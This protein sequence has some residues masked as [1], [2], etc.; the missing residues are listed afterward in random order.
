MCPFSNRHPTM[1][2][3]C[4]VMHSGTEVHTVS[5]QTHHVK[6][7]AAFKVD[8]QFGFCS[9]FLTLLLDTNQNDLFYK[10]P[11]LVWRSLKVPRILS[12]SP[13][14]GSV[15]AP[16]PVS[17]PAGRRAD[18]NSSGQNSVAFEE[19]TEAN[20]VRR[21]QSAGWRTRSSPGSPCPS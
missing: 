4:P 20:V 14:G 7:S 9:D 3:V 12:S 18:I 13:S 2:A 17:S 10:N 11:V 19:R 15:A 5:I 21:F 16:A 8:V 1:Q 6:D